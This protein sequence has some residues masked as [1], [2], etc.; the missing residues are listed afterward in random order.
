[1]RIAVPSESADGLTSMRSGHFGHCAYFTVVEIEGDQVVS[2]DSVKNV[3]HDEVGCGGVIEF[4]QGLGVDA[5]LAA[6]MG[7]PPF[8][9]FT[10]SGIDVYLDQTAPVVGDA[11]QKLIAGDVALMTLDNACRH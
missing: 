6:G 7:Q 11:V 3:D 5:I 4:A 8:M 9:R 2:V 1:M 10:Q